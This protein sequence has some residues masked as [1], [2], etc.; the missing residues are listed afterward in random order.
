MATTQTHGQ[1]KDV[2][3][4]GEAR[5]WALRRRVPPWGGV[6]R[7]RER[8]VPAMGGRGCEQQANKKK[9]QEKLTRV[10]FAED[11]AGCDGSAAC[12]QGHHDDGE[13]VG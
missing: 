7:S 5:L 8:D 1:G 13:A 12:A 9:G 11:G 4:R 6:A 2:H 10:K 3:T